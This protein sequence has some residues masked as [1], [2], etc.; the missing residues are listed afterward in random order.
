MVRVNPI[1]V[2][3]FAGAIDRRVKNN[4]LYA[5]LI[6]HYAEAI[7]PTIHK[8]KPKNIRLMSDLVIRRNQPMSMQTMEN[9]R[10]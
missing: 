1:H 2:K 9:N 7:K 10:L 8:A 3:R 4:R 6:A 5:Q